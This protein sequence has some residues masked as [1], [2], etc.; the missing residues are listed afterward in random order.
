MS[1]YFCGV[2]YKKCLFFIKDTAFM[3]TYS[4]FTIKDSE[5]FTLTAKE[6]RHYSNALQ[7]GFEALYK[8]EFISRNDILFR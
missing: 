3:N 2:F 1:L 5:P 7:T 6:V 8:R 4:L